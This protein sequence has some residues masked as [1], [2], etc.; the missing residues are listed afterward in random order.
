MS[1]TLLDVRQIAPR[2]RH[3]RV[4]DA[5]DRMEV[6]ETILLSSDRDPRPLYH[7]F[8]SE[9]VGAFAWDYQEKGP[10]QWR[11]RITKTR[12]HALKDTCCGSCGG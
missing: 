7:Q 4:F 11:I 6:G 3:I 8:N 1:E 2:E 10:E 12:T 5:F 9:R